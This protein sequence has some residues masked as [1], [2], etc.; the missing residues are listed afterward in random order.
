MSF[1]YT[2]EEEERTGTRTVAGTVVTAGEASFVDNLKAA[3]KFSEYNNTSVSESIVMEEQWEPY[4]QTINENREKLGLSN[5]VMNPGKLLSLA[6]FNPERKYAGYE[7]KVKEISE[8]IKN[9]PDLFGEFS[10][11]KLIN[12]AKE[13]A[14]LAFKENKEITERSPSFSNVLAR[15]A[16]E[17][18]S[19]V[20][21][22]VVIGSLMF[23][24]GP[25]KL[26]QLALNQAIIGAGSEALI[27]KNVKE[28]YNKTGLEYTD[29]QFWQAIAFGAGFG[30]ASPF[31]FRAGGKTIS[32]TSDQIK[33]GIDAYKKAGFIKPNSKADLLVKAAQNTED[34]IKSNPLSSES[35]HLQRLNEAEVAIESNDLVNINDV[36]ESSVIPPK[37]V[38]ESDNLNNEV[39]KFNPDDLKVDAKLF[40]FKAGGDADGVTDALRG[41]KKWDAIKSG[42]IVVY[43]YAD[44]RQFIAD[45]HQR[46]GLA[47]RL[48]AE[49]QDVTLYGMKLREVDGFTPAAARV[50]AA[51]KNI[52][53]GTGTAVDAAKVLRVDPGKLSEL[54]PRSN[55]VKQARAVVNLTDEL[56]GMVVNDVVPAKFAA[57]V[58]RLIPDDP[59]LQEAAMR[60]LARNMPDNEFQ[61][62]AIVRQVIEAGVRKETTASLFGDEV[63]A[64]SFFVERAKILDMAQKALRQDKNA[65][66]NLVNNAERL[67]AEGNLLA[68]NA[69]QERVSRDGQAITLITTLANRKGQ[70][71][72]ALNE[73]ARLARESGNYTNASRGFINSVRAAINQGDFNR[74]EFGNIRRSFDGET[75]VRTSENEPANSNLNDFDE[76]AGPGS[77]QQSNQ[78]EEDQFGELRRQEGFLSDL[79]ARQDLNTKLDQGMTDA[80][81]DNHPAVIKAIEEA[82][83]IPKTNEMDGYF[84]PEWFKNREFV[85]DGMTL[86]GY[87]DG[88]NSLIDRA[89]K[90][91]YTDAKLEVP[92][93]YKVKAE[94]KAVILLG[95]PAAG[96]ST[97]ANFIARK[98]GAA[99]IDADDAKKA[100]PEF[101]GGIGAAAVHE[102][103]SALS[104]LVRDLIVDE[105]SN[106][107]IPK[108][109]DNA[110][111]IAKQIDLLK[112]KGYTV[113]LGHMDVTPLNALTR[114][115]KRFINTGRLVSP[116]YVRS[117]GTKPNA[118]YASLKQQG[119]ADGYAQIDNNQKLGESPTIREDTDGIFEGLQFQRSRGQGDRGN[120]E[121]STDGP[122][123]RAESANQEI[124]EQT[125]LV[126]DLDLEIPTELTVDGDS[127]RAKTQTLKQLEEEFAQDQRMLDRL[128]G[129]VA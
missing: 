45:G 82:D 6:I 64:E 21:D 110:D 123:P 2:K 15:L 104:E 109:G 17:A 93:G 7:K 28:W 101:Q 121:V 87:A 32:F 40:Q 124:A 69:N 33:K 8:I 76:P 50:T 116:G 113:T 42:Q 46:L 9:N 71:S 92:P 11:E 94:K 84:G 20:Q 10:H 72:D 60:V 117:I 100:L 96:K 111:K 55:L 41:V 102:E 43:E 38:F 126:D 29:A 24:N 35:E 36:P 54:P 81:I 108:V 4:I 127:I 89:K 58:G 74:L 98:L 95:P 27:Q 107:V 51:L 85:I 39:F 47:K 122:G 115:L 66:Q 57:V 25:G 5:N 78:L 67:E 13:Q 99:I 37:N 48:K 125:S 112:A 63:M 34:G 105:G 120:T 79:E 44:G 61:A 62:D 53:E 129:C 23:G 1:L 83:K 18:G 86:K 80:E 128:E 91:A 3:Y 30:A 75:K 12:N 26:Y 106:I 68:K 90:L 119:K 56:F 97:Q 52:A 14:R 22:P 118:T 103:S 19:L 70:L 73:A 114:M 31:V 77:R 65:F 16:G 49:G 88:V 59:V